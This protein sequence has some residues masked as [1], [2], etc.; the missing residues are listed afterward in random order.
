MANR[1]A[2]NAES[3]NKSK[4]ARRNDSVPSTA[5]RFSGRKLWLF[6]FLAVGLSPVLFVGL[7]ELVLRLTGFGYPTAFLLPARQAEQNVFVQNN[8]FGWRFF[9]REM[10]RWP[11][12]FSISQSK[13]ANTVRIFVLGE[14]A[15]RGEPQPEFGL[16]RVLQAMLSLKYPE[17]RF[18]VVNAAMTAINSHAILPIARDCAGAN[19]DIWVIYMGNNE[20]VGPFGAGTVFGSQSPPLPLIRAS[21]ALKA[22]RT[23]QFLDATRQWIRKSPLDDTVWGGMTLFLD[24]QVRADDPRMNGVYHHFER[25]LRD[26]IRTGRRSGVGIVVSTVAVNLKDCAPFTSAHRRGLSESDKAKWERLYQLGIT[27]QDAGKNQEAAE[28]FKVAAQ[29]DDSFAELRFR[30]GQCALA[31]GD[32]Q[33]AQRHLQAARD[34]DTLRFRCDTKLNELIRQTATNRAEERVLLADA[35]RV[36]G[37]QSPAGLPGED[38]F[39]EHVHLTFEGNYLLARTLAEQVEKVLPERVVARDGAD[40]SWPS[41]TDCARRLGR[42]DW[43]QA[44]ALNSIIATLNDPPFTSQLHHEA[45]MRRLEASLGNLASAMQPAGISE[46]LRICEAALTAAADDPALYKQ[47]A[48]LKKAAGDFAGA[49][50][51]ARRE[52]ELLPSDSEGWSLLGSI[53]AQRQQLEEAAVAFRR[54]FQLGPQGIKSSLDLAGALAALGKHEEAFREYHRILTM[55]PR[56]VPALLQLGQVVEKMGR[57][58]EAED[59]F[60][61]ALTNRS[62]RLPELMEL[63]AFFQSR[64]A[65]QA[66]V[67]IYRDAIKLNPSNATLQLGAGR[68]LASLGRY[69]EAAHH[70]AEAVRLAPEFV[71]AHLLHGIVLWRRGLTPQAMEQFQEALRLRPES[72]DARLNLGTVLAQLGRGSEALVLFEEVLQRSPTNAV[73]LKYVQQLRGDTGLP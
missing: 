54:A 68:N 26:I 6:R 10:A 55:K 60:R 33:N 67:D 39:Y 56:C 73:A 31:L 8:Q 57:K 12:P 50:V 58:A 69:E 48:T 35:E 37:E 1:R 53:L 18:E 34:L 45:Q 36:F 7:F 24:Q 15:A 13:P 38:F 51:A 41:A 44:A 70:S 32:T 42:S 17:V 62:Q 3:S 52:L 40:K 19:G 29:L 46:A 43:N 71:E 63:G 28:Y 49:A 27:A 11:Y 16:A 14:S 59:Y 65:F 66:A 64:G 4:A 72:M 22:T 9:G 25:N 5:P 47:L 61:Q 2:K 21:L 30:Q 20:V 23:G